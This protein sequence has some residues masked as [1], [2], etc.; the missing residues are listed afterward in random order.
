LNFAIPNK[1]KDQTV[2][3]IFADAQTKLRKPTNLKSL[4]TEIDQLDWYSAREEGLGNL[5]EGLLE[6]NAAEKKSGAGQYF[7]PRRLI[8]CMV[9]LMKPQ[10]GEIIQDPAAGTG[11]FLVA[12]DRYIKDATDELFK[13]PKDKAD[14][15]RRLAYT[16][17]E[18]VPDT[19]RLLLM[20]LMLHGIECLKTRNNAKS[21]GTNSPAT[22]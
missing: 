11:G 9:R 8:D 17:A 10:A 18:L 14:F 13:L 7:T 12:A 20:N 19:N 21:R 1:V 2:L 22:D 16:G 6:K 5:Y 3:A 4:T 15:Q